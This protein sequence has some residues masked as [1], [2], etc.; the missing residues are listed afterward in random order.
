MRRGAAAIRC[1]EAEVDF[2]GNA[3]LS[4]RDGGSANERREHAMSPSS[5]SQSIQPTSQ[6]MRP[7]SSSI[8]TRASRTLL[9]WT[10]VA[11][12]CASIAVIARAQVE[13]LD[14]AQMVTKTDDC[15]VGTITE[16]EV[17]RIDH[18]ID[19]SELYFTMLTV[20]GTL[21][22]SGQ[23][24]SLSILFA[25]G[26]VDDRHGVH[27]SE[28]PSADDTKVGTRVLA[29]YKWT[30]NLGGDVSGNAL[31]AAHG[32]LYRTFESRRGTIVQGRGEGYAIPTNV[33]LVPLTRRI[34]EIARVAR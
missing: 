18:P 24:R 9:A 5:T 13:R 11:I 27:N 19:G 29:F 2:S 4:I 23:Q 3:S 7:T 34:R 28:A 10:R 6:P 26:F 21:V 14:L 12:A 25:G 8:R 1:A 20:D 31:Y 32:G 16:R 33:E 22:E 17:F 15:V 30:P